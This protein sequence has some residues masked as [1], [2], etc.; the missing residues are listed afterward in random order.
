MEKISQV[1]RVS[2]VAPL[3][4]QRGSK[5]Q[6]ASCD[7]R[8]AASLNPATG[9]ASSNAPSLIQVGV[10]FC[11]KPKAP[12]NKWA[13]TPRRQQ[14]L[15]PAS[16][17]IETKLADCQRGRSHILHVFMWLL[18]SLEWRIKALRL[19]DAAGACQRCSSSQSKHNELELGETWVMSVSPARARVRCSD[20]MNKLPLK[21]PRNS[22]APTSRLQIW[23]VPPRYFKLSSTNGKEIVLLFCSLDKF[24]FLSFF[25]ILLALLIKEISSAPKDE[26]AMPEC[27][28]SF[29]GDSL[30]LV[31]QTVAV[32]SVWPSTGSERK[33][34]TS[35]RLSHDPNTCSGRS[36]SRTLEKWKIAFRTWPLEELE[37][38]ES[39]SKKET[40]L[41]LS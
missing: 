40:S 34:F 5:H 14:P 3:V 2:V 19:A 18:K 30:Q 12:V 23:R 24:A 33:P 22:W 1:L 16:V 36:C 27:H 25:F 39:S 11:E 17:C 10:R 35:G 6:R 31:W 9:P 38:L 41:S 37:D 15:S 32:M 8:S 20:S 4:S 28:Q 29:H 21:L 7:R 26:L 13:S